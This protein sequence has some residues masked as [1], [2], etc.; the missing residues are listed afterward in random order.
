MS[1][2]QNWLI[3]FLRSQNILNLY[4]F[5]I[6]CTGLVN[7]LGKIFKGRYSYVTKNGIQY[8]GV[9][10]F[11]FKIAIKR[12]KI[13]YIYKCWIISKDLVTAVIIYLVKIWQD[14]CLKLKPKTKTKN[15]FLFCWNFHF[16]LNTLIREDKK[17]FFSSPEKMFSCRLISSPLFKVYKKSCWIFIYTN[18]KYFGV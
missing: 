17:T 12:P 15:Q 4:T 7:K 3:Q 8:D 2:G 9:S 5:T 10:K 18:K 6:L 1:Q 13:Y 14:L 11:G 16:F